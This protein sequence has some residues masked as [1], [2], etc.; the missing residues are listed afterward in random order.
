[1]NILNLNPAIRMKTHE[2]VKSFT[3]KEKG[4]TKKT[5]EFLFFGEGNLNVY[6]INGS[7]S[8]RSKKIFRGY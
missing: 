8:R 6:K 2:Q 1:V 4:Y 5:E 7:G 3:I